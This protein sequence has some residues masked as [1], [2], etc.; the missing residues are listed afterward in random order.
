MGLLI[1]KGTKAD[2]FN[3]YISLTLFPVKWESFIEKRSFVKFIAAILIRN[4]RAWF[5]KC[6]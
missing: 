3:C 5:I 1:K 6:S 2:I 4:G